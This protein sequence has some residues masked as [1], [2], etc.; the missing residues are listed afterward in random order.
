M[1]VCKYSIPSEECTVSTCCLMQA[2]IHYLPN[3]SANATYLA[4][5]SAL[6]VLQAILVLTY[7]TWK[8]SIPM[9]CGVLLEMVGYAARLWMRSEIFQPNPFILYLITLTIAPALISASI[10]QSLGVVITKRDPLISRIK[11]TNYTPIFVSFDVVCLILQ[12]AGGAW[13]AEGVREEDRRKVPTGTHIMLGGLALQVASLAAFM[14]LSSDYAVRYWKKHYAGT[15]KARALDDSYSEE[16]RHVSPVQNFSFGLGLATVTISIRCVFRVAE[17]QG[18]FGGRLAN[19]QVLF[20]VFE[21]PM[22][23]IAVAVLTLFHPGRCL[24][25]Q[26]EALTAQ[27]P[28]QK[29]TRSVSVEVTEYDNSAVFRPLGSAFG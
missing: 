8:F 16:D 23:I 9:L 2:S 3:L 22:I 4:I 25:V 29:P 18:G 27:S 20:M 17:L 13:A 7:R 28:E 5:F 10:Y 6:F 15:Q 26:P 12:A 19:D 11:P 24:R 1:A 14:V 21:G